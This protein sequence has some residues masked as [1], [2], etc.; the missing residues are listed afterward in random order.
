MNDKIALL[1]EAEK[2]G[3]LPPEKATMLAEARKRGLVTAPAAA[4]PPPVATDP[5]QGMSD[6]DLRVAGFGKAMR[7]TG[8]GLVQSVAEGG[9]AKN[10]ADG[11]VGLTGLEAPSSENFISRWA[12]GK[13]GE[14]AEIDKT[15]TGTT[16]GMVGNIGGHV[17]MAALPGVGVSRVGAA[18]AILPR[19]IAG[20]G[21]GAGY[22][23]IQ[24]VQ[25]GDSRLFNTSTG[26]LLGAA[27]TGVSGLLGKAS[28]GGRGL[29]DDGSRRL[30]AEA[31]R[32]GIP[33]SPSQLSKNPTVRTIS[34]QLGR[35]PFS[36]SRGRNEASKKAF[37]REVAKTFGEKA[38]AVNSDVYAAAKSRIG[39]EFN[40]LTENSKLPVSPQLLASLKGAQEEAE[41]FGSTDA[42]RIVANRIQQLLGKA[43][44]TGSIP[45][46]AYQAFDSELGQALKGGGQD[47]FYLGGL[48]DVVRN[49]MGDAIAPADQAA[50]ATARK[51]YGNL[52]T[53]RD[54]VSKEAGDGISPQALASRVNSTGA[55]KERMASGTAGE[56]GDLAAIGQRFFKASPDSGSADRVLVNSLLAGGLYGGTQT[57]LLDPETAMWTG[58]LLAGNRLG[59]GAANNRTARAV[60][61]KATNAAGDA[62][63]RAGVA[64]PATVEIRG[65]LAAMGLPVGLPVED[66]KGKKNRAKHSKK[67]EK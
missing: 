11:L 7:D 36:G 46:R 60:A 19:V 25:E 34:D 15:L 44:E 57:G 59:L 5:S 9:L 64:L 61:S 18:P 6:S 63:A 67:K 23:A 3:I 51:Q 21:E 52:K 54:L 47:A 45:G 65:L 28:Q 58:G 41:K 48:R 22:S 39:G 49:A 37:N 55:G 14:N 27:G 43:D 10:V 56:L 33:I 53:V 24:P 62:A 30:L 12:K 38:D 40:R 2:R 1:I 26:G 8:Y 16:P 29:L 17:A 20:A 13:A 4:A 35:L 66:E 50:W 42:G 31:E 32:L